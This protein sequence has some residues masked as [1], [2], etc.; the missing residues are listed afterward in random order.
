MKKIIV[1]IIVFFMAANLVCAVGGSEKSSET[2]KKFVLIKS[3]SIG[4][5]WYAAGAAWAK[6]ISDNTEYVAANIGSPGLS[7]ENVKRITSREATLGFTN[8]AAIYQAYKGIGPGWSDLPPH[9]HLRAL[10]GLWPGVLNTIVMDNS[11]YQYLQDLKGT[12]IATYIE[13]DVTGEQ[14]LELLKFHGIT[15]ENT[16]I[17][18]VMKSDATRMFVDYR[19]DALIYMFGYGHGDLR[20]MITSKKI[21]FLPNDP[22]MVQEFLK[23]NPYFYLGD[24]GEEI[25]IKNQKQLVAPYLTFTHENIPDEMIYEFTRVWFENLDWLETILPSNIPYM[26]TKD[27]AAGVPIPMHPGAIKYFKDVGILK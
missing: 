7:L 16:K 12:S 14:V 11:K 27:P 26:N 13:G 8:G 2:S 15:K 3:S 5:S 22:K 19:A 24:F 1:V 6:L 10:F 18:Q 21:R 25:E 9:P 17:Y 20:E 23:E 4:G